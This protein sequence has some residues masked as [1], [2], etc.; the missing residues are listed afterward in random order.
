MRTRIK[1]RS[2]SKFAQIGQP[3]SELGALERLKKSQYTYNG[4][5]G[6]VTFSQLSLIE[7]FSYLQATMTFIHV[8][9]WMS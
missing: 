1:A 5:N 7:S 9:A 2:I 4:E 8:R 6:V 3:T